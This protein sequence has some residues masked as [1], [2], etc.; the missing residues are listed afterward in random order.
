L[1]Y[2]LQGASKD[3][4]ISVVQQRQSMG[5]GLAKGGNERASWTLG[6]WA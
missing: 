6:V 5:P 3:K 1:Q 4:E 2:G